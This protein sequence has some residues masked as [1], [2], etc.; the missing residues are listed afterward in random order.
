M[1]LTELGIA[2]NKIG[3]ADEVLALGGEAEMCWCV[4]PAADGEWEVF[5]MERGNKIGVVRL[6]KEEQACFQL[7]G[8]LTYSQLLGGVIGQT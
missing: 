7:L 4:S 3:I 5:W 8:R 1:N 2:L 6:Q